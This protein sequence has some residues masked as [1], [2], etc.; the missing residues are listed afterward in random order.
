[1]LLIN[2]QLINSKFDALLHHITLNDIDTCFIT[3]KWISNDHDHLLE[4]DISG[5]GY[6][7][8][9]KYRENQ[10]VGGVACTYKGHLD[11]QTHTKD[12]TNNSF[13]YLTFKL[14]VKLKLH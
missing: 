3:E 12:N 7:I 10:S 2:L 14:M 9:N 8:I 4:A 13:E 11:I 5:L 6:K 1:M